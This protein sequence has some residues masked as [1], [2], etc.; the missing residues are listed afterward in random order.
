MTGALVIV[1]TFFYVYSIDSLYVVFFGKKSS[2]L[3]NS[4]YINSRAFINRCKIAAVGG[5][6]A[7]MICT[8]A[9]IIDVF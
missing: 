2:F 5:T 8:Y 6:I 4:S 7:S 1:T 3:I 9:I